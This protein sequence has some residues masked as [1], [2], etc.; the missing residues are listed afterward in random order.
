MTKKERCIKAIHELIE[1]QEKGTWIPFANRCPLCKIFIR[2]NRANGHISCEGCPVAYYDG[3]M[4]CVNYK[5]YWTRNAEKSFLN[6]EKDT[7]TMYENTTRAE[8]WEKN[9]PEIKSWPAEEFT[10]KGWKFH[11]LPDVIDENGRPI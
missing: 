1:R 10:V 9:L 6:E 11:G 3:R 5:S 8:F 7:I 4:G 2:R